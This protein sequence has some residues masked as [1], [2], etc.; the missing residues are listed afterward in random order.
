MTLNTRR[1]NPPCWNTLTRLFRP[2]AG[3]QPPRLAGRGPALKDLDILL[4]DLTEDGQNPPRD[5]ALVGPRGNGKTALLDA[6]RRRCAGVDV[7]SLAA[8]EIKTEA[9]LGK[10]LLYDDSGLGRFLD[11]LGGGG[12]NLGIVSADWN[13]MDRAERDD[14]RLTH[15]ADLLIARCRKTPL[16]VT[17][18]EAHTLVPEVG[19]TLLN[20]SQRVRRDGAPFLLVLAGTPNLRACLRRMDSTFWSRSMIVGVGRLDA[21]ATREALVAPLAD[22]GIVFDAAALE[23][24]VADSQQYPYFIQLWGQALCEALAECQ[25]AHIDA[26]IVEVARPQFTKRRVDYYEDRFE[27]LEKQGLQ[28]VAATVAA[29]FE[30]RRLADGAVL[31]DRLRATGDAPDDPGALDAL[32][33]LADLGYVWKPPGGVSYEP[34]IPSLMRWVLTERDA[35][36][37]LQDDIADE[38]PLPAP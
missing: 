12:V 4:G 23:A 34:G 29:V 3:D 14:Y 33:Q 11:G 25:A 21:A 5:A 26:A 1:D 15:L 17:V 18:D 20:A 37:A 36:I 30:G 28:A 8:S 24:V 22:Y 10:R 32:D 9:A 35:H 13:R 19:Q 27:E 38:P 16:V 6:F 31:K 2:G 7:V